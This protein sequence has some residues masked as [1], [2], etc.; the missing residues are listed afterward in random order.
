MLRIQALH[1][2]LYQKL[3]DSGT[4][5]SQGHAGFLSLTV[6]MGLL[7]PIAVESR[8]EDLSHRRSEMEQKAE[9]YLSWFYQA[10]SGAGLIT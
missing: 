6:S 1:D 3:R 4:I 2:L 8:C 5:V 10:R 7:G 9:E